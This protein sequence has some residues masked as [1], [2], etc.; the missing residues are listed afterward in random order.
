MICILPQVNVK[1]PISD[2]SLVKR[3]SRLFPS[4]LTSLGVESEYKTGWR[5]LDTVMH[6]LAAGYL[7]QK[8]LT[9][10]VSEWLSICRGF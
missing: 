5:V 7:V 4:H 6:F 8:E 10:V 2:S 1:I 3:I 9:G